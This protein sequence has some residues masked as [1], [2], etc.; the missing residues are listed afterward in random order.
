MALNATGTLDSFYNVNG[1]TLFLT[2]V[3]LNNLPQTEFS[4]DLSAS[5]GGILSFI[6]ES[7]TEI[8]AGSAGVWDIGGSGYFDFVCNVVD[9]PNCDSVQTDGTWSISNSGGSLI[10]GFNAV[11]A[12]SVLG[13]LGLGLLGLGV[14]RARRKA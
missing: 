11:P 14:V 8:D 12:P 13:L 3:D 1:E 10:V 4:I 7:G 2:D 6:I 5:K 9:D